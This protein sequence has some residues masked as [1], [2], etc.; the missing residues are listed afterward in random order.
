MLA[1]ATAIAVSTFCSAATDG[2]TARTRR[3]ES[4]AGWACNCATKRR[5]AASRPSCAMIA[6]QRRGRMRPGR[7]ILS[8]ISWRRGINCAC[9]RSSISS[10]ASRRRCSRFTCRGSEVVA[11][12]ERACKEVGYPATIRVDHGSEFVSRDLDLWAYQRGVTLDF[13]R[14]A[15]RPTMPSSKPP[16][17]ASGPHAST[18]T[19]SFPLQTPRKRWR[20]GAD[21]TMKNVPVGQ[22]AIDRRFCCKTAMAP[23][24]RHR[25]R[26]ANV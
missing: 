17:N 10:P 21:T 18:I 9:S 12:L 2:A 20:L 7:W 25:D 15:S 3:G 6:G 26:S 14:P 11:I 4:I 8:T 5:S 16:T 19:G 23:P 22:S 1:F 24:A 13:S